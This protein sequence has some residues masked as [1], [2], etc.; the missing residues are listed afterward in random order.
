M[1][2][3]SN[4]WGDCWVCHWSITE[5]TRQHGICL[6]YIITKQITTHEAFVCSRKPAFAHL[7][8]DEKQPFD[9]IYDLYKMKQFHWL[10]CVAKNFDWS[11]KIMPLSNLTRASLLVEWKLT[12]KVELSC[13]IYKSWRSSQLLSSEQ[14]CK[15]K[16]FDVA[17]KIAVVEKLPSVNLWLRSI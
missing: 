6:F 15:P 16:S 2:K 10:L 7:G 5:Q 13:K 4:W 17:L 11:R 1:Q 3:S 12:A 14:P 9:V 8:D